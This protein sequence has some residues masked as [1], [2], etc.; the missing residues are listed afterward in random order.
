MK[1][2]IAIVLYRIERKLTP[3]LKT[4]L[5]V[6]A[7]VFFSLN[8][9]SSWIY[10]SWYTKSWGCPRGCCL[11]K[12]HFG[13][14]LFCFVLEVCNLFHLEA[15]LLA[16]GS[17]MEANGSWGVLCLVFKWGNFLK[18]S[19]E[20][21]GFD[22]VKQEGRPASWATAAAAGCRRRCDRA[23]GARLWRSTIRNS[24]FTDVK[25]RRF[26]SDALY[27]MFRFW[28]F[29]KEFSPREW[30]T[31]INKLTVVRSQSPLLGA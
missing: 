21:F 20:V 22:L 17:Q 15:S 25:T 13:F 28:F 29:K 14:L 5:S 8:L 23:L 2:L 11:L 9:F 1:F 7:N 24:L 6:F 19:W 10:F 16:W 26:I 18:R 31:Q 30:F 27:W 4:N 12:M 3:L